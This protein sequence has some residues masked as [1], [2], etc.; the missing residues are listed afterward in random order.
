MAT[1]FTSQL[2]PGIFLEQ[3]GTFDII[4]KIK[5]FFLFFFAN[6]KIS[7]FNQIAETLSALNNQEE[8]SWKYLKISFPL[9]TSL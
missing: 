9:P 4:S 6:Q 8:I 3:K 1:N 2:H 5:V 7:K